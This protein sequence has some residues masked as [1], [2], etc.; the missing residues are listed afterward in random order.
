M[1]QVKRWA[2]LGGT[3][4]VLVFGASACSDDADSSDGG[5][6]A[7]GVAGSK[8]LKALSAEEQT[9]L[10][11]WNASLTSGEVDC[12]GGLVVTQEPGTPEEC[13]AG[14]A[15]LKA[16]CQA[17]V[18]DHEKCVTADPCDF[19]P[20]ACVPVLMCSDESAQGDFDCGDGTFGDRCDDFPDCADGSDEANCP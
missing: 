8:L 1:K 6:S 3:A 12:G 10:C 13:K 7:S 11:A 17:T 16:D 18:S 14:L 4:L 9:Q 5:E 15:A 2:M 20:A 19:I